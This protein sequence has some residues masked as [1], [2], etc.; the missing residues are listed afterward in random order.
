MNQGYYRPPTTSRAS[1][2]TKCQK[3]LKLDM[4]LL[5]HANV[6]SNSSHDTTATNAKPNQKSAHTRPDLHEAPNSRTQNSHQNSPA[7]YQTTS[8]AK[9]ALQTKSSQ[10]RPQN[11]AVSDQDPSKATRANRN[12]LRRD[13]CLH[14]RFLLSP[15]LHR[16]QLH[17]RGEGG[18]LQERPSRMEIVI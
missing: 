11:A 4:C 9:K 16:G 14:L 1:A 18:R 2:T 5:P 6:K 7:T 12:E 10:Q 17:R 13:Q 3:C 8:S 15:Q